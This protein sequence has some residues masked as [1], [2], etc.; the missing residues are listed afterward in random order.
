MFIDIF[1]TVADCHAIHICR[2]ATIIKRKQ[3]TYT[4][5]AMTVIRTGQQKGEV[6]EL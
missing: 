2:V 4:T 5:N 3:S 1:G 6:L